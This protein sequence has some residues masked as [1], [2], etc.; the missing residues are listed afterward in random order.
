MLRSEKRSELGDLFAWHR[1]HTD[2]MGQFTLLHS[3][4]THDPAG[5]S[6]FIGATEMP[7]SETIPGGGV[8]VIIGVGGTGIAAGIFHAGRRSV[9]STWTRGRPHPFRLQKVRVG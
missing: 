6:F 2:R 3:L 8:D 1:L 9:A 4:H 7:R 5:V